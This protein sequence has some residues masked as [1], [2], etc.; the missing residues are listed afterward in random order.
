MH[1]REGPEASQRRHAF[2]EE[3]LWQEVEGRIVLVDTGSGQYH[4]LN[5]SGSRMWTLLLETGGVAAALERLSAIYEA[6]P[7]GLARDLADFIAALV[8]DGL[9]EVTE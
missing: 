3:V 6:E 8:A 5:D 7:A 1:E 9:L 4:A 2:R